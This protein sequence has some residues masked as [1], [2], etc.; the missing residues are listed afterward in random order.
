MGEDKKLVIAIAR[1]YGSGGLTLAKKLGKELGLPVYDREILRMASDQSGINEELF[2]QVDEHVRKIILSAKGKYKGLPLTPE[3][4]AFTSDD[5]LFELQAD[6]IKRI[7]NTQSCIF[8]GRCA[9]YILRDRPYV[10][11][12]FFYASEEDCLE[13]L[14]KQ[15]SGTDDELIKR[16]HDIDKHR[17]DYYRY[18][19]GRDWNDARNYDFCLDTGVMD[20]DKLVEV[21]KSYIEIKNR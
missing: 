20:Y 8:V 3:Y 6:V 19:T 7:A 11:S 13:R 15:V 1:S 21:V 4:A 18:Y 2:G 17:A 12:L 14:R 10:L 16:M 5:N 9:D